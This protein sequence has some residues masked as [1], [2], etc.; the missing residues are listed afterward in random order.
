MTTDPGPDE[1]LPPAAPAAPTTV[2]EVVRTEL[3]KALG[4]W[5]G[6]LEAAVPILLFVVTWSLSDQ[7]RTSLVVAGAGMAVFVLLRLLQRQTLVHVMSGVLGLVIA[8]VVAT[9]TGNASDFFLPGILYNA[10]L[11]VVFGVSMV[12]GWPVVGFL[13][14]AVT[15]DPTGWRRRRGVRLLFQKLTAVLLANYVIRVVVQ[16]PLYLAGS[17]VA[18]GVSKIVL[19]WPLLGVS[20]LVIGALLAAGRTPLTEA[21]D[22]PAPAAPQPLPESS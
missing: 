2:E 21:D 22:L 9:R 13:F 8:A 3:L 1:A 11:A 5:R 14:G 6:T 10:A 18:L 16:L 20:V 15:G 4:G 19:G 12:T 17:V 7:L